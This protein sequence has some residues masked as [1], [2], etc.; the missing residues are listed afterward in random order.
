VC[1]VE[2]D[3]NGNYSGFLF[4]SQNTLKNQDFY[5]ILRNRCKEEICN[6]Q[7]FIEAISDKWG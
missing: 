5:A 1:G 2:S 7:G 4:Y 3:C 6:L